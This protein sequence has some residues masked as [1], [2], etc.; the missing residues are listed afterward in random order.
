MTKDI[1]WVN[2]EN[3]SLEAAIEIEDR[4]Q[5]MLGFTE[6]LPEAIRAFDQDRDPVYTDEPRKDLFDGPVPPSPSG[7]SDRRL[8]AQI[9]CLSQS[10]FYRGVPMQVKELGHVVLYVHDLERSRHFYGDVLV[11]QL[12]I[13]S[14]SR[15]PPSRRGA[16]TTSCCSSR[17]GRTRRRSPWVDASGCTTSA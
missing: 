10:D 5:L 17:S 3:P 9:Q 2:L 8:T 15:R 1:L 16:P 6:N 14:P 7:P 13:E 4:N 12:P 11:R